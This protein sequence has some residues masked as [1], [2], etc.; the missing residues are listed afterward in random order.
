[1]NLA[2]IVIN[3]IVSIIALCGL[4]IAICTLREM[5]L[6]REHSYAPQL[7]LENLQVWMQ[8]NQN[9]TPCVLK[10]DWRKK[11][12]FA[13]PFF[14]VK[15]YN[16]GLGAANTIEIIWLYDRNEIINKFKELGSQTH[17]LKFDNKKEGYFQYLFNAQYGSGYGFYIEPIED[18]KIELPFLSPNKSTNI[19]I[20]EAIYNYLTFIPFLT[21]A[22]QEWPRQLNITEELA[23][24]E[25]GY[26]DIGGKHHTQRLKMYVE[27]YAFS[28]EFSDNN[29]ATATIK[30]KVIV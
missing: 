18:A 26:N 28:K 20:P 12:G 24:I 17:L 23:E 6:Q 30:F 10:R 15:I 5:K 19:R 27:L 29:Y 11:D 3:N 21:L 7:L 16:I 2:E 13:L 4:I 9:G 8:K 1:M 14:D 22:S 25:L